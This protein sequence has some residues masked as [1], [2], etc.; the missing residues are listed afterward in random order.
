[1][2]SLM[3]CSH[4]VG[5][6]WIDEVSE[7]LK[8]CANGLDSYINICQGI[9]IEKMV[10]IADSEKLL[11]VVQETQRQI[12][13][14]LGYHAYRL[15]LLTN[16]ESEEKK[17][18]NSLNI[19]QGGIE[20]R[21]IPG[22]SQETKTQI[23]GSFKITGSDRLQSL[24]LQDEDKVILTATDSLIN[25]IIDSE[26]S[27]PKIETAIGVLQQG[28]VTKQPPCFFARVGG[29]WGMRL[30]RAAFALMIKFSSNV[31]QITKLV[32]DCIRA[33]KDLG[34]QALAQ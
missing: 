16:E 25:A 8:N 33:G 29:P 4:K 9:P 6:T 12:C 14:V 2:Y 21:F 1:M 30:T 19:L 3:M 20:A 7:A 11:K 23:E 24:A 13:Y 10:I 5:V 18:L 32:E 15:M 27:D 31:D 26:K 17:N 22:L 34:E 28:L